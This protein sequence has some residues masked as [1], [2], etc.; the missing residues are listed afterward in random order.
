MTGLRWYEMGAVAAASLWEADSLLDITSRFVR[1]AREHGALTELPIALAA[2]AIADCL[3]GRLADAQDRW[4]EL[5]EIVGASRSPLVM[6]VHSLS[7][8]LV[9]VYTG[10][11]DAARAA[12]VAQVRESTAR[13]QGGIANIGR[14]IV[15]MADLAAG[16]YDR[17]ADTA[18]TVVESDPTFTTTAILP[19]LVEAAFRGDRHRE[20]AAAFHILSERALAVGTPW[21]LGVRSR[22][23]ALLADGEHAEH[24]YQQ[25]IGHLQ[26]SPAAVELARAHLQYGQWLRR[27]K[28]RRDARHELRA[29]YDMF[30][31]MGAQ[32][33]AERAAAEL[34]AVGESA[35]QRAPAAGLD[36]TP[37]ESRVAALAA[38]GATNNQIAAQLF[39][40]PRTV[41]YHLGKV[42]AKANVSSRSQLPHR[43]PADSAAR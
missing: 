24:A 37:Q 41:D 25:A 7:E 15:A 14:V 17:A 5:R 21:A 30:Q 20:A 2:R 12:G 11:L 39:I 26:R 19:E 22:C 34:R 8:G 35:R 10:R 27:T 6:G 42:F 32:L 40:S 18:T 23:A 3:T 16:D 31:A 33:I 4:A 43:L 29:A 38:E 9:L 13:G 36:L 1:T 28:R